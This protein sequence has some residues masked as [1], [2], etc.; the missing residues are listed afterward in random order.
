MSSKII[1]SKND[2][3]RKT[4]KGCR[5]SLTAQVSFSEDREEILQAV[6]KFNKFTNEN[7]PHGEHDFG[8]V[9]VN[10]RIYYFKFD[11]YDENY[12]FYKEDGLRLLTIMHESEY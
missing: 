4:F 6:R 8:K 7:D 11:Y 5:I 2:E 10:K 1:A 9:I 3:Y 12:Q